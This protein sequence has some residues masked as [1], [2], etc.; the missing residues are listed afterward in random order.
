M[1]ILIT[2]T[3]GQIGTNLALRCLAEGHRVHGLDLRPNFWTD[4]IPQDLADLSRADA[5]AVLLRHGL[6]FGKPDV[7]VHLAGHAKVHQ[8]MLEPAKA[9]E[10]IAMTRQVLEYCRSTGAPMVFA[11][12]REVY[13]DQRRETT[14]EEHADFTRTASSTYAAAKLSCETLMQASARD[15]GLPY[16][17]FRLSNVY[18]RYDNDLH[19]MERVIPL[20]MDRLRRGQPLTLFGPDK[21]L[22][23]TYVD[24]CVEGLWRGIEAL[25]AG[26]VVNE[27]INLARGEGHT[28]RQLCRYL[29][30]A[31][32]VPATILEAPIRVGEIGRYVA[33]LDKARHLLGYEPKVSLA[34]GIRRSVAWDGKTQKCGAPIRQSSSSTGIQ[35]NRF[36]TRP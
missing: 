32:G 33:R 24:D 36:D 11:S 23:F 17:V 28:L 9:L 30:E 7:V 27:T 34:E 14:G 5:A 1:R 31:L 12:S 26:R 35:D 3:S 19:R 18:G 22:D 21:V 8:L 6:P 15:F 2:G 16:L 20:F 25:A 10:N 29:S 4:A 13:G